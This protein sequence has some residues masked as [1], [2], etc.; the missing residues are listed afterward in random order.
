M[1]SGDPFTTLGNTLRSIFYAMYYLRDIEPEARPF[2]AAA[3]DDLIMFP[4]KHQ[5]ERVVKLILD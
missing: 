5:L 2:I 3:G 4:K 1:A